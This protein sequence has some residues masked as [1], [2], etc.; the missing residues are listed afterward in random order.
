MR[1]RDS[2]KREIEAGLTFEREVYHGMMLVFLMS[3]YLRQSF[4]TGCDVPPERV[5]N[6]GGGVNLET[7][8][9]YDPDKNYEK[10][11]ILFIRAHAPHATRDVRHTHS[12][13]AC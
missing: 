10:K 4:I 9:T 11:N 2:A 12:V 13:S 5:I 8:P 3:E 6:V 7:L 1:S